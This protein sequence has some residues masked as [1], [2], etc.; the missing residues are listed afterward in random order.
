MTHRFEMVGIGTVRMAFYKQLTIKWLAGSYGTV[1]ISIGRPYARGLQRVR[2]SLIVNGIF[3]SYVRS[4]ARLIPSPRTTHPVILNL[5]QDLFFAYPDSWSSPDDEEIMNTTPSTSPCT[6]HPVILN[7]F[8]DLPSA[9]LNSR[10]S[11]DH[12]FRTAS[13][14]FPELGWLWFIDY[15]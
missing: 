8:Q 7:L 10:P 3:T 2:K 6:T 11:H 9:R 5:F 14:V 13:E 12:S 1:P 4:A 15:C